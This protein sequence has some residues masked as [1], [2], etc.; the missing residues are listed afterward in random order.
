MPHLIALVGRCSPL[1]ILRLS[2]FLESASC[3][4]V[5]SNALFAFFFPRVL[6]ARYF[7]YNQQHVHHQWH[8]EKRAKAL[9][10]CPHIRAQRSCRPGLHKT[11]ACSDSHRI[12]RSR[13]QERRVQHTRT[14]ERCVST[15]RNPWMLILTSTGG[16]ST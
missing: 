10:K 5:A 13:Y 8:A 7:R 12:W 11:K 2:T 6:S 9:H 3:L 4:H 15:L 14:A 16:R 1:A